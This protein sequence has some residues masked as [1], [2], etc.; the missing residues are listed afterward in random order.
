LLLRDWGIS[1]RGLLPRRHGDHKLGAIRQILECYPALPFILIGDSGQQDP[2]IYCDVV[3]QYRGRILAVYIRSVT[4]DPGRA[5]AIGR[6]ADEV[7]SAG[8]D[9]LL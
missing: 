7:R 9:L 1:E 6:L 2:E 3:R 5:E 4:D 8:S